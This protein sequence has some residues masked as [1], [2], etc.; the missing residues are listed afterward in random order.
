MPKST[1]QAFAAEICKKVDARRRHPEQVHLLAS[2]LNTR[3]LPQITPAKNGFVEACITAYN[4]HHHLIIRPDDVWLAII[5]Q[6]SFFANGHSEELK[7]K[8][9]PAH[10]R[11]PLSI[12]VNGDSWMSD[13]KWLT[14]AFVGS[15]KASRFRSQLTLIKLTGI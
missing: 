15:M 10:R 2:S 4:Q 14:K 5:T 12:A 11:R 6:F 3:T 7:Y 1:P 9:N 13:S 8:I